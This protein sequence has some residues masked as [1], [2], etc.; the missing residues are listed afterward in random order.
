MCRRPGWGA[1]GQPFRTRS[2][3]GSVALIVS[4]DTTLVSRLT[5][6]AAAVGLAVSSTAGLP[7]LETLASNPPTFL[8][9]D[10]AATMAADGPELLDLVVGRPS[11]PWS[12]S[13]ITRSSTIAS[14]SRRRERWGCSHGPRGLGRP[15]RSSGHAGRT[16]LGGIP[17]ACAEHGR[18]VV[19]GSRSG[20]GRLQLE[21]LRPSIFPPGSGRCSRSRV[22][23]W[24]SSR[25]KGP[26]SAGRELCRVIR[27]HPRWHQLP[28]VVVEV[29][30]IA[31]VSEAMAAGADDYLGVDMSPGEMGIRI[32]T[33]IDRN[34]MI[35]IRSDI[36]PLTGTRIRKPWISPWIAS[37]DWLCPGRTRLRLHS[38]RSMDFLRS[39]KER[40][41]R[42]ET[43]SCIVSANRF[44]G[45]LRGED[46]V[47]RWSEDAFALGVYG[48]TC[49]VATIASRAF[50]TPSG[51]SLPTTSVRS[52]IA[53]QPRASPRH[54]SM[55]QPCRRWEELGETALRRARSVGNTASWCP[56]SGPGRILKTSRMS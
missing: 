46:I 41:M 33:H 8:L 36:D 9:I 15:F 19:L 32:Q 51:R 21:S 40:V 6:E 13:L 12:S 30:D 5:A 27:A 17:C 14:S 39:V 38:S 16:A 24:S 48:A 7:T 20:A 34:R 47:G 18:K 35:Q 10:D 22:P 55:V 53:L 54:R 28:V 42:W 45:A 25:T 2:L 23:I 56:V 49:E 11:S 31:S 37:C 26:A 1:I 52:P 43:S 29:S 44:S 3:G 50:C 4:V